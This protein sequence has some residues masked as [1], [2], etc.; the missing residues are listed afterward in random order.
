MTLADRSAI[1]ELILSVE[2]FN[3]L[4]TD[5]ALELVDIYLH[6]TKQSDYRVAVAEDSASKL[7]GYACWG[8]VPLTRGSF[9]LYW[10]ATNPASR[11]CGFG[12]ALMR[13]VEREAASLRGRLLLVETSSKKSYLKTVEFY[14]DLGY[15]EIARIKDFY[16]VGDDKLILEKRLS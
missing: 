6:D 1:A 8:P 4:E 9:D 14:R 2:N 10:I 12:R 13:H 15:Q 5:C 3:Q 7:H 11:G 16:D